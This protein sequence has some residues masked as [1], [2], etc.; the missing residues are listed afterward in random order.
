MNGINLEAIQ[1]GSVLCQID[2]K[3]HVADK[4]IVKLRVCFNAPKMMTVGF[5][6]ICHIHNEIVAVSIETI[7]Q[8]IDPSKRIEKKPRFMKP[9]QMVNCILKFEKNDL[10]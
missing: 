9:N 7:I 2:H 6:A 8:T 3:C 1:A 4:A 10:Y 5:Q